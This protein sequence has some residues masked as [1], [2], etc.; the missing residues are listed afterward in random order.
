MSG[1]FQNEAQESALPLSSEELH[2]AEKT[3]RAFIV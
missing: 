3:K 1:N 2:L